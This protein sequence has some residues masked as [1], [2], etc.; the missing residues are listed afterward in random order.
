MIV[1]HTLKPVFDENS[2]VLILGS[3][4]SVKSRG[5]GF[6]YAHKQNR[7]W[8][9]MERLFD[10][11][12]G[13]IEEKRKFLLEN[14]IALYDVIESCEI[15]G[16]SDSSIKN[17]IPTDLDKIIKQ[18]KISCIFI[19]GKKAYELYNKYQFPILKIEATLLPSTSAANASYSL[20]KLV[21]MYQIVKDKL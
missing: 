6:Y 20:D 5:E 7:F 15:I 3:L 9:I 19:N 11:S 17:V 21:D 14:K 12:L 1:K 18:T 13:S 8:K 16:S 4:P 10:V 2:K